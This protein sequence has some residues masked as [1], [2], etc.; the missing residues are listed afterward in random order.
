MVAKAMMMIPKIRARSAKPRTIVQPLCMNLLDA[1]R[2]FPFSFNEKSIK[3]PPIWKTTPAI[4]PII[5]F[6]IKAIN[7]T[8]EDAI[9]PMPNISACET[10][11]AIIA[12]EA[13]RTPNTRSLDLPSEKLNLVLSDLKFIKLIADQIKARPC[14]C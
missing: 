10:F 4:N 5:V 8:A 12:K 1:P 7:A 14:M 2:I 11:G 13:A 3:A 9:V 6:I